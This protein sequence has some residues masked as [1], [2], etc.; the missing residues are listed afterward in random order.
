MSTWFGYNVSIFF[1]RNFVGDRDRVGVLINDHGCAGATLESVAMCATSVSF[2]RIRRE[3]IVWVLQLSEPGF[4]GLV[5]C[6]F[7]FIL[8]QLC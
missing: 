5:F 8:G 1:R 6:F 3:A 7:N 2:F 4:G